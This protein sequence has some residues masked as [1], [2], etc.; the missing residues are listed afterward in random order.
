VSSKL[1]VVILP[2]CP[3]GNGLRRIPVLDKLA[4][5]Q[6]KEVVERSVDVVQRSLTDRKNEVPLG[7]ETM[8]GPVLDGTIPID[9]AF[10]KRCSKQRQAVADVRIVLD[11][12]VWINYG[13]SFLVAGLNAFEES[14]Y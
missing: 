5:R 11:V 8:I 4:F 7:Q 6:P 3:L 13:Y 10:A 9:S 1:A 2:F 14:A 12:L